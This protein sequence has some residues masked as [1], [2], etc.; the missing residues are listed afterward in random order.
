MFK[1]TCNISVL[2]L[3]CACEIVEDVVRLDD[4][5]RY[6]AGET[7]EKHVLFTAKCRAPIASL[8]ANCARTVIVADLIT[9]R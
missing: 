9:K 2:S 8:S 4:T 5:E 6:V 3:A 1:F 7:R